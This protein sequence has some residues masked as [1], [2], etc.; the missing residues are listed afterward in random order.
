MKRVL[1]MVLCAIMLCLFSACSSGTKESP[2]ITAKPDESVEGATTVV[3]AEGGENAK[4]KDSITV[5][6]D[7]TQ[8]SVLDPANPQAGGQ[9]SIMNFNCIHDTLVDNDNGT[10]VPSLALSWD[11]DGYQ[12]YTFYLRDDVYF[13]NGE[14]FTADDVAFTIEHALAAMGGTAYSRFSGIDLVEII[15]KTTVK[16]SLKELNSDFLYYLYSPNCS[17]L[18]REACEADPDK[19]PWIGTGAWIVDKFVSNEYSDLKVNENYW[20]EAPVTKQLR[21]IKVAEEATRYMMLINGEVDVA[22]GCGPAD[23]DSIRDNKDFNLYT[24]TICNTGY[25]GFNMTDPL[26]QDINFRKAVACLINRAD[27]IAGTRYG[28]GAQP[29]SGAFWGYSTMYKNEDLPLQDYDL[30]LAKEYLEK[31]SYDGQTVE[32]C[33]WVGEFKTICQILQSELINIGV[34]ATFF[35]TDFAGFAEHCKFDDNKSQIISNSGGWASYPSSAVSFFQEG[36]TYNRA[37]YVNHEIIELFNT[38]TTTIDEAEK[39]YSYKEAQRLAYDDYVYLPVMNIQHGVGA[40]KDVGGVILTEENTHD[41]SHVFR[42][43]E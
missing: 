2:E 4:Y 7:N 16:I 5:I 14:K 17:I 22:F 24:Y 3:G 33:S 20:G 21:F 41:L 6:C 25:V 32:L 37:S 39:E 26:M 11:V 28:Y 29:T 35:E 34:N 23:F 31:S 43:I 12:H 10:V 19:G 42:V 15:D 38:A 40:A 1:S 27:I 36:S 8:M 18:N 13:H 9:G 30:E